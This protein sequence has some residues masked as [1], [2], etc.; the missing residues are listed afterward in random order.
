MTARQ[1]FG[2]DIAV[3]TIGVAGPEDE[4]PD[5]PMG[6]VFAGLAWDGGKGATN[7]SWTGTRAEVRKRTAKMA[8]N[9][10][11]LHLLRGA[12]VGHFSNVP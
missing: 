3:S 6:L 5:H 4:T 9:R 11:R 2:A 7:F 10:V 8:I 1:R 12:S